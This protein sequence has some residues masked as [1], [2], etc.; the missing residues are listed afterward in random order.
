M[1]AAA[2]A[3]FLHHARWRMSTLVSMDNESVAGPNW[4][5]LP[6]HREW[7]AHER[8]RLL[9][10]GARSVHPG[11]GFAWLDDNGVALLDQPIHAYITCRM[12]HVFSLGHLLGMPGMGRLVDHG[13]AALSGALHDAQHGGWFTA[14]G[15][16]GPTAGEKRAYEH[17]FV[18]LRGQRAEVGRG[19]E[20]RRPI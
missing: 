17:A 13:V 6:S 4:A 20:N 8:D 14:V 7:L 19:R 15:A 12:T 2:V 9:E 10:F 3:E 1:P 18:V 16:D 5:T 11:G